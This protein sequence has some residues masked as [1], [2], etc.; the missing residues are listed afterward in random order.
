MGPWR[1]WNWAVACARFWAS[2]MF[3]RTSALSCSCP[4]CCWPPPC[5]PF[6]RESCGAGNRWRQRLRTAAR[7]AEHPFEPRCEEESWGLLGPRTAAQER[8]LTQRQQAARTLARRGDGDG[9]IG[10]GLGCDWGAH[11]VTSHIQHGDR[12]LQGLLESGHG[13]DR[14]CVDRRPLLRVAPTTELDYLAD[15]ARLFVFQPLALQIVAECLFNGGFLGEQLIEDHF[16]LGIGAGAAVNVQFHLGF[17]LSNRVVKTQ[18]AFT[19]YRT[20]PAVLAGRSVC[21]SEEH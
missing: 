1:R 16:V 10:L 5:W 18:P 13:V 14:R 11:C 19:A 2:L 7:C 8:Q 20:D 9:K 17:M 3:S 12:W 6:G 21:R 4:S 15:A